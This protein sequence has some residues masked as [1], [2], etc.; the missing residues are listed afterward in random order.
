MVDLPNLPGVR[1]DVSALN[2]KLYKDFKAATAG[3]R[4]TLIEANFPPLSEEETLDS[5]FESSSRIAEL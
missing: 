5:F 3:N 4:G 2:P 1:R